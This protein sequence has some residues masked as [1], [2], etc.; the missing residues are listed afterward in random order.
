MISLIL[1][2]NKKDHDLFLSNESIVA[3][4]DLATGPDA[5]FCVIEDHNSLTPAL[6]SNLK[7]I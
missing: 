2:K 5:D 3:R 6:V 7:T 4:R 1:W